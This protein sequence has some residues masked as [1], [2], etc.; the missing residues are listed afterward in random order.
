MAFIDIKDPKRREQIVQD[1]IKNLNEIHD[2]VENE[3]VQ[4]LTQRREIAKVFQPIVQATEKSSNQITSEIKNLQQSNPKEENDK[5]NRPTSLQY[6]FTQ[7]SK[8][9]LDP[10]FGIQER[11]GGVYVMGEKEVMIDEQDNIILDDGRT[12]FKGT[13]GL[14]RLVMENK[15]EL[16]HPEDLTNYKE[17]LDKTN[18]VNF[19]LTKT[20]ADRPKST[21]KWAFF[22]EKGYVKTGSGV[23]T[24]FLPGDINGLLYK[25]RLLLAENRAG[26]KSSTQN[27]IVA[28]LDQLLQRGFLTQKEYNA[29]CETLSC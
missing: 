15:P 28:I 8:S 9:K 29:V 26:N 19:P 2:R 25:L 16:F 13:K 20:P 11:P 3:K 1:Y 21:S 7:Y 6:F 22:K 27:A 24:Q 12:V 5:P 18:A 17:L 14:W 4:G 10:Y 23:T